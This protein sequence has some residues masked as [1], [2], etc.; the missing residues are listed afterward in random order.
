MNEEKPDWEL[1]KQRHDKFEKDQIEKNK[2]EGRTKLDLEDLELMK[3]RLDKFEKNK[4]EGRTRTCKQ[5][6]G[7]YWY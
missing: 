7:N 4:K 6:N 2:K 1:I 5:K 3:Q